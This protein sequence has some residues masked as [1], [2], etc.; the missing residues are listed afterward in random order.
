MGKV[1]RQEGINIDIPFVCETASTLTAGSMITLDVSGTNVAR[2]ISGLAESTGFA[3][4]ILETKTAATTGCT[5]ATEGVFEFLGGPSTT[6]GFTGIV[7]SVGAPVYAALRNTVRPFSASASAV[8]GIN[9]IGI[10]A[11]LP[12]GIQGGAT[13]GTTSRVWVKIMPFKQMAPQV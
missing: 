1:F 6:L 11:F 12:S 5:L 7:F 13:S 9:P 4:V 10:C 2:A 8:T 3:G